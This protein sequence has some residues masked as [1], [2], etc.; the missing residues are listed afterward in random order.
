MKT[1]VAV[2]SVIFALAAFTSMLSLN[3]QSDRM[4]P[5]RVSAN[6]APATH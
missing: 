1:F 5:V 3:G 6:T 4:Q 2:L